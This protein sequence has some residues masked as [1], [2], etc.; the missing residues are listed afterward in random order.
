M[1]YGSILLTYYVSILLTLSYC[2]IICS[3]KYHNEV[4]STVRQKNSQITSEVAASSESGGVDETELE[5]SQKQ[6]LGH[7]DEEHYV[8]YTP[9][10]VHSE[11]GFVS[12][13]TYILN[14]WVQYHTHDIF[15]STVPQ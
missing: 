11:R 8:Q 2:F 13:I 4:L 12:I 10:D 6:S 7:R 5:L 9:S 1:Y 14:T 15:I 3:R